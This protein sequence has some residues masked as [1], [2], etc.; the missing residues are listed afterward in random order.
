MAVNLLTPQSKYLYDTLDKI[1]NCFLKYQR[2]KIDIVDNFINEL[3]NDKFSFDIDQKLLFIDFIKD[4][5]IK[6]NLNYVLMK[7]P[8]VERN[9][10]LNLNLYCINCVKKLSLISNN[11]DLNRLINRTFRINHKIPLYKICYLKLLK[12]KKW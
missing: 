9:N 1:E 3:N 5:C 6:T 12:Y 4:S 10:N 7:C 2:C 11:I 8:K